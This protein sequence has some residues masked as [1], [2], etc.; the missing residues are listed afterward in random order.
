MK[1]LILLTFLFFSFQL[2]TQAL[3]AN[4]SYG[5]FKTDETP[6]VEVYLHVVG[7]T[8]VFKSLPD[9]SLQ[10]NVEVVIL[11]KQNGEVVKFDKYILNSPLAQRPED[12]F[13]V[14]RYGLKKGEYEIDVSVSDV[15]QPG[16]A[17]KYNQNFKLDFSE[18]RVYQS[19]IQL[20]ASLRKAPEGEMA[21]PL[22]KGGFIFEP[23][24]SHFL[25]KYSEL[26]IFYN[27]I[28]DTDKLIGE[29]FMVSYYLEATNGERTSRPVLMTHKRKSPAPIIPILQK[30]EILE[31]PSG[32]YNLVTE[33]KNKKGDLL[34]RKSVSFQRSNPFFNKRRESIAES[35]NNLE[36][37]F[38]AKMTREELRYSLKAIAMQV[39]D[40]DGDVLNQI[41]AEEKMEAMQLYLFSF[42][43][44]ENPVNP[45]A[46]YDGY[47]AVAKAIDEKF[48][49]GFGYGFET[50]RGY[51]YMKYGVPN[52]VI[53]EE[54]EQDAPPYE[55][56]FYDQFPQTGQ[57]NVKFLFY[58]PALTTN[59]FTLLHSTAR[60]EIN[61][62]QWEVEL[63][64][65]SPSARAGGNFIDQTRTAAGTNRNARRLFEGN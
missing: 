4:I 39:D 35:A 2:S 46:A 33:V 18:Q 38:T 14:K 47:M 7:S 6:Y 45:K 34:S 9:S 10:A 59:G 57:N 1:K 36:N 65:D 25:D 48:G 12:F 54:S 40:V 3:D 5:V 44:N 15:N 49:G 58:N 11:F 30:I 41:L 51:V 55:I 64:R 21:S 32:N 26:L 24:P 37:E 42:W 27:E 20:L 43:A 52:N 22:A 50:D 62:P 13:D 63:Y 60:G 56:W 17:K 53:T 8:T 23:L 61:N 19:D 16:N 31:I 29:D 28:Y